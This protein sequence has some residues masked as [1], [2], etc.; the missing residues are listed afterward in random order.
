M[1]EAS[2]MKKMAEDCKGFFAVRN[3]E[4]AEDYF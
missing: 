3:L 4:E 2:A 1:S